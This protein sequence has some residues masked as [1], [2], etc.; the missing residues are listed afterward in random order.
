MP[1]RDEDAPVARALEA[2]IAELEAAL[3]E[4]GDLEGRLGESEQ[5]L[6]RVLQGSDDGWW[7]WDLQT[8]AMLLSP[9]WWAIIGYTPDELAPGRELWAQITHPDDI[10]CVTRAYR[11]ALERG[12]THF[13]AESRRRHKNGHWVPVLTRG[14]IA[15]DAHGVA[16]RV[17][18]TTTDLSRQKRA[19]QALKDSEERFRT[20]VETTS[21]GVWAIDGSGRTTFANARMAEILGVSS[22]EVVGRSALEFML[23]EDVP[24][25][26]EAMRRRRVGQRETYERRFR[27]EDGAVV[28]TLVSATPLFGSGG[29]YRGSFATLVDITER[30]GIEARLRAMAEILDAAPNSITVHDPEGR[31]L[32]ANQRTCEI[33]GYAESEFLALNLH[34]VDVPESAAR[35]NERIRQIARDGEARFEVAHYRKD[36]STIPLQVY[37]KEVEWEG[38]PAL[39]SIATDI[40][41][42]KRNEASLAEQLDELR[43]WMAVTLGRERR[44]AEL[45]AEVNDFARRC[46]QPEPYA[47][48]SNEKGESP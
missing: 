27:R 26:H 34:D 46:G 15:R 29:E 35:I 39:M 8:D 4:K 33:H 48:P 32:Y 7:D 30:K 2:R 13:E 22:G 5:R 45:K 6:L 40:T 38:R 18:G 42:R 14:H 12:E 44:I 9:R 28:W 21:V 23:D 37:V 36:G 25:H 47:D 20:I 41:E 31:F 19:E 17:S 11:E 10:D 24:A 43:R 3:R 16:V 1:R